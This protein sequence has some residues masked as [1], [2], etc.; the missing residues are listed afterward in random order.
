VIEDKLKDKDLAPKVII[1]IIC[2]R[3]ILSKHSY[4]YGYIT[5]DLEQGII[6]TCSNPC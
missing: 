5:Y 2:L 3:F 4:S 1:Q 6:D